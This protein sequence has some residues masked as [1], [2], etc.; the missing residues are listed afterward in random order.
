MGIV[1]EPVPATLATELPDTVPIS[2]LDNTATFAGPPAAQPATA[3]AK[4][5]KNL[6]NPV[7]SR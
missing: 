2:P 7:A 5:I 3:F 6:P 4:S 1:K